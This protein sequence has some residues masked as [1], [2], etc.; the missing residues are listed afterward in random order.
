[1][2]ASKWLARPSIADRGV[3][4]VGRTQRSAR[5]HHAAGRAL[6]LLADASGGSS[7]SVEFGG[8]RLVSA[9]GG[10]QVGIA[11][12]VGIRQVVRRVGGLQV[13]RP[14]FHE[15]AVVVRRVGGLRE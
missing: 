11:S 10:L 12:A 7:V 1:M 2:G 15:V 6:T 13:N 3:E 4:P 14:V 5:E 8:L 9:D